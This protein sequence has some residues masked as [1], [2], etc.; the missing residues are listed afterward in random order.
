MNE[1]AY[2][3]PRIALNYKAHKN[4]SFFSSVSK[5]LKY[6]SLNDLYWQSGGNT[7]L[8]PEENQSIEAGVTFNKKLLQE[9]YKFN[10][11]STIYYSTIDN[12]IQ[13]QPTSLGYWQ[14]VNL[15]KVEVKG[16]ESRFELKQLKGKLRKTLSANYTY[17]QSINR[18]KLSEADGAVDQQLIYLPEHQGNISLSLDYKNYFINYQWQ[19]VGARYLTTDNSDWLPSY[20]LSNI[21]AGKRF[22]YKKHHFQLQAAVLNL[23]DLEYQAI[24]WR[25]MP[26]RNYQLSLTYSIR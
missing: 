24:Q 3:L 2:L 26:N 21:S 22:D 4:L 8:R 12:Y 11:N 14:A 18:T 17:T 16:L 19:F 6:P 20:N 10:T 7:D 1:A 23:F 25:P 9:A 13:W 15:R 5:N